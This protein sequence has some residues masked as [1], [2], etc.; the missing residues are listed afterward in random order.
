MRRYRNDAV[1]K[2]AARKI[3]SILKSL[4]MEETVIKTLR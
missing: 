4:P 3:R 2:F 1:G